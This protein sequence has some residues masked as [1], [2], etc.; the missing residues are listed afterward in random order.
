[1]TP[2]YESLTSW[3]RRHIQIW[4]NIGERITSWGTPHCSGGL[5]HISSPSASFCPYLWRKERTT[6]KLSLEFQWR[7]IGGSTDCGWWSQ[8]LMSDLIKTT[9]LTCLHPAVCEGCL[10]G[11][12]MPS[13]SCKRESLANTVFFWNQGSEF[14]AFLAIIS[15][16]YLWLLLSHTLI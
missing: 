14:I 12:P 9:V 1:M 10:W 5:L 3:M 16:C 11:Q 2:K 6:V 15:P 7:Q 8:K 13:P 4:N